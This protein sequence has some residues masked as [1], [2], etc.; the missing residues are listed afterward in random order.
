MPE[1]TPRYRYWGAHKPIADQ[2]RVEMAASGQPAQLKIYGPIDDWGAP[3]GVS[4]QEFGQ[5]LA[6][7][8]DAK[9]IDV[10]I[11]SPGGIAFE[12][13]AIMNQLR[14]HPAKINAIV[15]GLCASAASVI[16]MGADTVTMVPGS[17]MMIHDASGLCIGNATDMETMRTRLD[18]LSQNIADQ[19]AA[20]AGGEPAD[21]RAAM[22]P[23]SWYT[24]QEAVDAGLADAV[25]PASKGASSAP[26]DSFDLSI[27]AHAGREH[28]PTPVMPAAKATKTPAEPPETPTETEE[29]DT[30]SDTLIQGL[31][32]RFGL[33]EDADDT[34]VLAK[35]DELLEQATK[36]TNSAEVDLKSVAVALEAD[37]KLVVS[38]AR[39]DALEAQASEGAKA[40][41]TQIE[42]DRDE[43]ITA[44][45]DAGK[46]SRADATREVWAK[47]FARD[48]DA[49]KA[50][51]ESL[52]ARFPVGAPKGHQDDGST[53]K[54]A[55]FTDDEA[56]ALAALSG[57][58]K[59][60][61]TNG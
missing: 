17:Q 45:M 26:T 23:E 58:S 2:L 59:E 6:Q 30:M 36:P 50:D 3:F 47:E 61:L 9:A 1:S 14:Q 15:D 33:P 55:V 43:L 31:R 35:A 56:A 48:F 24:A 44:A 7:L 40:R 49:A 39:F 28:A 16:A 10:H 57:T 25:L 18:S 4:A 60:A 42:R 53:A 5:A 37:G 51:L 22:Q 11:H 38:K 32:E 12:G 41:A 52:P 13:V 27:F 46:I 20:K 29:A 34:A 54:S 8:S 19:Y 21:W